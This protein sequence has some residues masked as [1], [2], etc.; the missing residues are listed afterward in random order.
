L[1]EVAIGAARS[2]YFVDVS[3]DKCATAVGTEKNAVLHGRD[4]TSIL[5]NVAALSR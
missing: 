3:A 4:N 1:P 5:D 2:C